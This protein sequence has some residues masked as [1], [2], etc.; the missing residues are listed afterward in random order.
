MLRQP[1]CLSRLRRCAAAALT[2]PGGMR[3]EVFHLVDGVGGL[4]LGRFRSQARAVR[5][6]D[7][8]GASRQKRRGHLIGR[9]ADIERGA[10]DCLIVERRRER[11]LVHQ[12]AAR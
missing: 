7:H 4:M 2:A 12:I 1:H 9:A 3:P 11:R 10:G 6:G 8:V 5:R